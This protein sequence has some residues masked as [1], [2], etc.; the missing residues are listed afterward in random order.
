MP[1]KYRYFLFENF[2]LANKGQG[3]RIQWGNSPTNKK[4]RTLGSSLLQNL[5]FNRPLFRDN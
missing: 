1:I 3:S 4:G 2:H 5:E